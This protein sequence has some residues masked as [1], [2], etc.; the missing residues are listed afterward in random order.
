MASCWIALPTLDRVNPTYL[1][2]SGPL[3]LAAG[4]S[5]AAGAVSFASPCVVPLVPGYLAYLAG[6]VGAETPAVTTDERAG[7]GRMRVAGAAMKCGD[8]R[9]SKSAPF[10]NIHK[11]QLL[12]KSLGTAYRR[13]A[14]ATS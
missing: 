2:M 9:M 14:A 6:L 3:L 8:G 10:L 11:T 7:K 13:G 5:L 1:A 4:V 12:S